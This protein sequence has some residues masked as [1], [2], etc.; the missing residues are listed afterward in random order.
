MM[1]SYSRSDLCRPRP[2]PG[3]EQCRVVQTE[4][5]QVM[6]TIQQLFGKHSWLAPLP[7]CCYPSQRRTYGMKCTAALQAWR[8]IT[9]GA[10]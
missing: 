10:R 3:M 4:E 6:G 2:E 7:R 9:G 1:Y 5:R 8:S